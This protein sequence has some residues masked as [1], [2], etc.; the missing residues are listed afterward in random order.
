LTKV[1]DSKDV[2]ESGWGSI[3]E[4]VQKLLKYPGL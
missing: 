1:W 3:L 2:N 4:R